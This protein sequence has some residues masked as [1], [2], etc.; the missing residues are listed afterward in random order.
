MRHGALILRFF[1]PVFKEYTKGNPKDCLRVIIDD[2][3]EV[4]D[5]YSI[6]Y[7]PTVILF[8]KG[9]VQKRL[10]SKPGVGLN[11]KQLRDFAENQ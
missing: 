8:K 5:G 11:K 9:E 6:K 7:Y 3:P 1:L 10:D 4:C 2:Y